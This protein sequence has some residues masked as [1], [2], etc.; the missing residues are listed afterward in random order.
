MK[1]I[2][3]QT[4]ATEKWAMVYEGEKL[5]KV[6]VERPGEKS[7]VGNL[8]L[9]RI[10]NIE[11]SLQ[12]AFVDFGQPKLGFLKKNE[13]PASRVDSS[14]S[15]E[16]LIHEGQKVWVQVTKDAFDDK[17]AQL[18][19]NITIPGTNLIYLPFGNYHAIS[20]RIADDKREELKQWASKECVDHEGIIFRTSSTETPHEGLK[21]ELVQLRERWKEL[22]Y[23]Q[24]DKKAPL[25]IW[26]DR[27]IPNQLLRNYKKNQIEEIV[28][29]ELAL[30]KQV[31]KQFPQFN[32]VCTWTA[33]FAKK[34]PMSIDQLAEKLIQKVV[35]LSNG[36]EITVEQTEAMVVVDV[37][38]SKH[39]NTKNKQ[40][41]ILKTNLL[42]A[43]E[44]ANQ[45]RL[46]NLS[47]MIVIDF[48]RMNSKEDK[49]KLLHELKKE[50][51]KDTTRTEV[52]GFSNLGLVELTRKREASSLPSILAGKQKDDVRLTPETQAYQLERLLLSYIGNEQ[53]LIVIEALPE[54]INH[55]KKQI[56]LKKL[57]SVLYKEVYVL[58][59]SK[60]H[61][62][63]RIVF[64]GDEDALRERSFYKEDT[65]DRLF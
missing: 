39:T 19:T 35:P 49:T 28:F 20:R 41:S 32:E 2:F 12:A 10:V 60:S 56:D 23:G 53:D 43:K 51:G 16:N 8:Y 42:A 63:F 21:E 26:E 44:A 45:I 31:E 5:E 27:E 36:A 38:T 22:T 25:L 61:A 40:Q 54:V 11:K 57:K 64:V 52:Y 6:L 47:G 58:N 18:T 29:D 30:K 13:I 1:R 55:F 62:S 34:L 17:G 65:L 33:D 59:N 37:N 4:M 7:L 46:R 50:L 9:G 15:I 3:I 24:S 48:I 14:K